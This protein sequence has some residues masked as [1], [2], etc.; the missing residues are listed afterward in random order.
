[1]SNLVLKFQIWS[2][3]KNLRLICTPDI[4]TYLYTHK[5]TRRVLYMYI[6]TYI[7]SLVKYRSIRMI[8]DM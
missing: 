6:K 5:Y 7:Y 3:L 8:F 4:N 1:M 2:T